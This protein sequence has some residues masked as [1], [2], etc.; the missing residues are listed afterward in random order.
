MTREYAPYSQ[1]NFRDA[2]K[3]YNAL[4]KVTVDGIGRWGHK[5]VLPISRATASVAWLLTSKANN[6]NGSFWGRRQ[7]LCDELG[8][9]ITQFEKATRCLKEHGFLYSD[10]SHNGQ[11]NGSSAHW[12]LMVP[13]AALDA[14]RERTALH[15]AAVRERRERRGMPPHLIAELDQNNSSQSQNDS[16][17]DQFDSSSGA[18]ERTPDD[19]GT[20]TMTVLKHQNDSSQTSER[21]SQEL[22]CY[23]AINPAIKNNVSDESED[24]EQ[25]PTATPTETDEVTQDCWESYKEIFGKYPRKSTWNAWH[26]SVG[27][28]LRKG[29]SGEQILAQYRWA[30]KHQGAIDWKTEEWGERGTSR[31]TITQFHMFD[32]RQQYTA[33]WRKLTS[34][35]ASTKQDPHK[36]D[37][38]PAPVV[39]EYKPEP[40]GP[41]IAPKHFEASDMARKWMDEYP[42]LKK[43][44]RIRLTLTERIKT[45]GWT[46]V[47]QALAAYVPQAAAS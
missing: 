42:A 30:A 29:R 44:V 46:D 13:K 14:E 43:A 8:I 39:A 7:D 15:R 35:E 34:K 1:Y 36:A 20:V 19:L 12:W 3:G 4:N 40:K 22:A 33:A 6:E 9:S 38:R 16:P 37:S 24:A 41:A 32:V 31:L 5:T 47:E 26:L 21:Q 2:L 18:V 17:Q 27:H 45:E 23:P 28:E 10:V 25:A 11:G